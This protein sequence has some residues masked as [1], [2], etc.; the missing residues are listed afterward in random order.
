M[1]FAKNRE[2]KEHLQTQFADRGVKRL[3]MRWLRAGL[4]KMMGRILPGSLKISIYMLSVS[5]PL[6][7]EPSNRLHIGDLKIKMNSFH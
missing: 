7:K 1:V 2:T 5:N 6:S 3:T 4:N